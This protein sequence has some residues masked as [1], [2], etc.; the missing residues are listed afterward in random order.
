MRE[1]LLA[2]LLATSCA[3][4]GVDSGAAG[5]PPDISGRYQV[6]VSYVSGCDSDP[7][8]VQDWAEGP[9]LIE[10]SADDLRF[11]FYDDMVFTGKAAVDNTYVFSGETTWQG[12][13]LTLYHTGDVAE[14]GDATVLDGTFE[15]EVDDDEFTSNN[16]SIESGS[17]ATEIVGEDR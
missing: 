15:I 17:R 7:S 4:E 12:A 1:L 5:A 2:A 8:W 3:G 14:D 10:G 13:T 6:F 11:D 16:C 9:L